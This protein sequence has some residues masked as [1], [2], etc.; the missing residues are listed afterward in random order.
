MKNKIRLALLI[1]GG[2][3]T[4]SAII[5]AC[6]SGRLAIDPVVVIASQ[7]GI[8]GIK[9]VHHAGITK[10]NIVVI[11]P[12]T[13][14]QRGEFADAL[15]SVCEKQKVDLVGQYGWLP[16][17]PQ[18]LIKTFH[19]R[20]INQ[21]PG[22]LDPPGPDFG[23]KGM[24]GRRVHCATLYFRRQTKRDMW[25]EATTHFVTE[26]FDEGD[27]IKRQRVEIFETDIVDDLQQ[28]ALSVEYEVQIE[29]LD[30][31]VHD[32]VKISRRRKPLIDKSEYKILD[33][34]KEI[35]GIL[36]PSG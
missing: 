10:S 6:K 23:G 31:F 18:K 20:I 14:S 11:D 2:G 26:R 12:T 25:T 3:T 36:Y 9:S 19:Q 27:V 32:R 22:A 13:F 35:A 21:H 29:A 34:S 4:A 33:Q 7:P 17:T 16:L 5:E 28:R 1:S 24:W 30:D 15:L 8:K